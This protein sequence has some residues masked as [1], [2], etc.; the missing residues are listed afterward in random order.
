MRLN[1]LM[2]VNTSTLA[3]GAGESDPW[4]EIHNLGPGPVSLTVNKRHETLLTSMPVADLTQSASAAPL[5]FPQFADGG[6]YV[7][8]L[9]RLGAGGAGTVTISLLDDAGSPSRP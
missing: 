6:G 4:L 3:D 7:T 9:I 8:Q 1:E 2:V 5:Y